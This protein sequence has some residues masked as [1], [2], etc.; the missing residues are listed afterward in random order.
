M[1]HRPNHTVPGVTDARHCAAAAEMPGR[2]GDHRT[3]TRGAPTAW[4]SGRLENLESQTGP[5]RSPS[6][7]PP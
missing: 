1:S 6:E 7:S 5:R 4:L 2:R 3:V